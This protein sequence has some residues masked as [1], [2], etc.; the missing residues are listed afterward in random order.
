MKVTDMT[1]LYVGHNEEEDFK[2][3]I[4][5]CEGIHGAERLAEGYRLDSGMYGKFEIEEFNDVNESFDC[6]YVII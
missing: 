2:I 5:S 4:C 3:L 1:N 6:D